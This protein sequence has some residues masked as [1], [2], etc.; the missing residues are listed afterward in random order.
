MDYRKSEFK[1]QV[2]RLKS[3]GELVIKRFSELGFP[4]CKGAYPDCPDVPDN[5]IV[6]CKNCPVW[7]AIKNKRKM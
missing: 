6:P 1:Q 2:Y 7:D 4:N 5:T 3:K